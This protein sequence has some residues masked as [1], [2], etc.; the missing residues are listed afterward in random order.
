MIMAMLADLNE[1]FQIGHLFCM[2]PPSSSN[3]ITMHALMSMMTMLMVSIVWL[4]V[5]MLAVQ[6]QSMAEL[7]GRRPLQWVAEE[8][9]GVSG[10]DLHELASEAARISV[11]SMTSALAS[12]RYHCISHCL[13]CL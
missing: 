2:H 4:N 11:Q 7:D 1:L 10:A 6:N 3:L 8:T 13:F 9:E 5:M 12:L